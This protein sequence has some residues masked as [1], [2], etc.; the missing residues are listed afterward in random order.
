MSQVIVAVLELQ[1]P[2]LGVGVENTTGIFMVLE[3][4]VPVSEVSNEKWDWK[5]LSLDLE[6]QIPVSEVSNEK[7]E[8]QIPVSEVSFVK[9]WDWNLARI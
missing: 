9:K 2:V 1:V 4:Q 5:Y 7:V 8:L 6:L 3:L